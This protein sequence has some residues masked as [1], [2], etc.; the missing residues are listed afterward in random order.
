M[1]IV[2]KVEKEG[3][4][5]AQF[6]YELEKGEK[7]EKGAARALVRLCKANPNLSL[8]DDNVEVKFEK[9]DE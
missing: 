5:V 4:P 2:M 6:S 7:P 9:V 3:Q 8:F 1:I